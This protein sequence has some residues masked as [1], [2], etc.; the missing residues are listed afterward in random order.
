MDPKNRADDILEVITLRKITNSA[1]W[2]VWF[3]KMEMPSKMDQTEQTKLKMPLPHL[4]LYEL[5]TRSTKEPNVVYLK[6]TL[7]AY[8]CTDAKSGK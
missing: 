4:D 7:C 6:A 3:L 2:D 1:T 8:G 5:H